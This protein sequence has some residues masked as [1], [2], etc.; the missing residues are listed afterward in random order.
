MALLRSTL[1]LRRTPLAAVLVFLA[2]C[3]PHRDRITI[4]W[5]GPLTGD[6]EP[7][8]QAVKRGT[9]LAVEEANAAGGI[10]GVPL[11]VVYEDDQALPRLGTAAMQKLLA[12]EKPPVIIQAAASSVMLANMP[13]A[14]QNK[15]V[16]ISPSCSSD[17]IREEK[18]R[19]KTRFIFRTWPSDSYQGRFIARF[20]RHQMKV[21][22]TAI[23]YIN[24]DYGAS[25]AAVFAEEFRALGG[26]VI[27]QK[28]F[29]Q[30]ATDFRTQ[31]TRVKAS[32]ASWVF[33]ASHY[34]EAAQLLRQAK[35]LGLDTRFVADAALFSS[36]LLKLAGS[37]AEGLLVTSPEWD[38]DS[39][40][41]EV[42]RFVRAFRRRYGGVPDIYAAAGYDL[43][44]VLVQALR[45]HGDRSERIRDGLL[46]LGSYRGV[47]GTIKF[48][49]LGEVESQYRLYQARAGRFAPFV[50]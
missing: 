7:Y 4:G 28:A 41:P 36:E 11:H 25:L 49:A 33:L 6:A 42:A 35:R 26:S 22:E 23:L 13:A 2:S 34:K 50:Q 14:E 48:D 24:N 12:V 47:A 20:L 5:I 18:I 1:V 45:T 17:K 8:G 43:I 39:S 40:R 9:E 3:H 10:R 27:S 44:G 31:L 46:S 16:Y 29:R 19:L 30:E 37:A 15:V 38:P 21:N 32:R